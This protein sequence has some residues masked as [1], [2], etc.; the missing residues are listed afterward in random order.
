MEL[1]SQRNIKTVHLA[2][3]SLVSAVLKESTQIHQEY[4]F[5]A[6]DPTGFQNGCRALTF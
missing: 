2:R 3:E 5:K 6:V 1:P 4:S